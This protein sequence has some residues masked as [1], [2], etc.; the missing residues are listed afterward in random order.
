MSRPRRVLYTVIVILAAGLCTVAAYSAS[1]PG[2]AQWRR[3]AVGAEIVAMALVVLPWFTVYAFKAAAR[4]TAGDAASAAWRSLGAASVLLALGQIFA[5]L[6]SFVSLGRADVVS[7]ALGQLL[8]AGFRIVLCWAL[9]RMR[10]A[11][12]ETGLDFRLT[13]IDKLIAV[14]AAVMSLVLI[15]RKEILFDYW[16]AAATLAESS[17]YV[18][19]GTQV[20]NFLLYPAVVFFSLTIFRYAAQMG[21]GLVARAWGSVAMYGLLQALHAFVIALLYPTFGVLVALYFDNFVVLLAFGALALGP[22]FQVEAAE[23]RRS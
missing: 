21:G 1:A 12:R 6:P 5:Y 20:F 4:F 23:V 3:A 16:T 9:W 17:R 13:G 7:H 22:V 2:N 8:P 11:Y 18:L 10:K 19:S 15:F 14:L